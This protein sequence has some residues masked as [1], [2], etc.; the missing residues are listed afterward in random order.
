MLVRVGLGEES[1]GM[2]EGRMD[3]NR[4][5]A[6]C[7]CHAHV[8]E[9]VA[10]KRGAFRIGG[11]AKRSDRATEWRRM[12]LLLWRVVAVHDGT[13]KII[14][15]V[16]RE[17]RRYDAP[18][19]GG[20][21]TDRNARRDEAFER[22]VGAG[23]QVGFVAAIGGMPDPSRVLDQLLGYTERCV[24]Q[25]PVRRVVLAVALARECR[26]AER[27]QDLDVRVVDGLGRVDKSAVPVKEDR[28]HRAIV[29]PAYDRRVNERSAPLIP[30][31]ATEPHSLV[32]TFPGGLHVRATWGSSGQAA[33]VF[34]LSE[35]G[36]TLVDHGTLGA[37]AESDPD[38]LC[39]MELR[40]ETPGGAWAVR[41]ASLIYDAPR[42]IH[43]DDAGLF[44]VGY[45]FTVYAFA[46]RTGALAWSH[47]TGTPVVELIA[48]PRFGHVIVQSEVETWAIRPD[49]DVR[50]RLA[51]SDVVAAAALMGGRLVLTSISGEAQSI[52][53]ATGGH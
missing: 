22:L 6:S 29:R 13:K 25:P 27:L 46:A 26:E 37:G 24:H 20:D 44:V 52:D 40:V 34:A 39:R 15:A 3:P 51:H 45:G 12:R 18:I 11:V 31:G 16:T 8:V 38:R 42:A 2:K 32:S 4:A 21:D 53:P 17:L 36:A 10:K 14:N 5:R 47:Q 35:A 28:L 41:L 19:A 1:F 23:E 9:R 50:W 48:S 49:G 43:W 33:A 30:S 7:A